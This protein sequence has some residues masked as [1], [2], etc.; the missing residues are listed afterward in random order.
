MDSSAQHDSMASLYADGKQLRLKSD[1][2]RTGT[3]TGRIRERAGVLMVQV[4]FSN[5]S[6]TWY[7]DFELD[8]LEEPPPSD[9]EA[10][11]TGRLGRAVDLRR[12][13]THIQLSGRL[14]DLVYSMNTTNTDFYAHQ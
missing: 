12:K 3:C 11:R 1:P 5:S 7:P 2:D 14:A 9:V 6:A 13:L 8:F 10:I 4:R